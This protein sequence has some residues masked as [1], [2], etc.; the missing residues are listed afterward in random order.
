YIPSLFAK[1][2]GVSKNDKEYFQRLKAVTS[3]DNS[4]LI[5]TFP[6]TKEQKA[7]FQWHYRDA[8]DRGGKL[9]PDLIMNSH[10]WP[11][12]RFLVG[13]QHG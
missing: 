4:L 11:H 6:F 7:H 1:I 13:L 9:H 5:N 12:K 8:L 3:F 10:W 2:S